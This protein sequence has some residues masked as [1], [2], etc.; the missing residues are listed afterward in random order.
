[1]SP[2][3]QCVGC[4]LLQ[5][6]SLQQGLHGGN[7]SQLSWCVTQALWEG[8]LFLMAAQGKATVVPCEG[9]SDF[10]CFRMLGVRVGGCM[11]SFCPEKVWVL[12]RGSTFSTSC[13]LPKT[14]LQIQSLW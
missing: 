4:V 3:L 7:P 14:P 6:L 8:S 1:M 10:C 2:G 5:V 9:H 11:D 12:S 13:D